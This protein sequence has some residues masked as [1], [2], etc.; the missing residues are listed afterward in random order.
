MYYFFSDGLS[1]ARVITNS[2][3]TIQQESDYYLFGGELSIS[4]GSTEYHKFTGLER[5]TESGLD[6]TLY[7]MYSSNNGRWLESDPGQGQAANP[8]TLDR[9][10]YVTNNPT[11]RTVPLS[12]DG[13]R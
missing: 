4:G 2:S 9:Y 5:D 10:P 12:T 6:D 8:Q 3:G 7:R 1:S 11:N 13:P